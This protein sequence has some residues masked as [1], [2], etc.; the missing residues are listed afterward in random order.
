MV[1]GSEEPNSQMARQSVLPVMTGNT[2]MAYTI[3]K[4]MAWQAVDRAWSLAGVD[5]WEDWGP[6]EITGAT[7]RRGDCCQ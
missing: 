4:E 6:D 2:W 7:V 1:S 5:E 3:A